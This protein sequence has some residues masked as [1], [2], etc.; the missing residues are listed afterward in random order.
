L[1][2][3]QLLARHRHV[4]QLPEARV[5]AVHDAPLFEYALDGTPRRF[6]ARPRIGRE[7]NLIAATRKAF[8]LFER[9]SLSVQFKH[10]K[11]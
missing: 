5:D 11:T 1:Q 3:A 4:R 8:D 2:L 10:E 6:D 9:Q 7:R